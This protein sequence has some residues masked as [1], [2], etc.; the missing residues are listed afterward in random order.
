MF[1]GEAT[2][3][4]HLHCV[5]ENLQHVKPIC[6]LQHPREW[7]S[8]C[9]CVYKLFI[10]QCL[11]HALCCSW[12]AAWQ[13]MQACTVDFG[14]EACAKPVL[15]SSSVQLLLCMCVH[16]L[17]GIVSWEFLLLNYTKPTVCNWAVVLFS[18]SCYIC[19]YLLTEYRHMFIS[20]FGSHSYIYI[21]IYHRYIYIYIVH[22]RMHT[23]WLG[24][25]CTYPDLCKH[26][27]A[28]T[29][30]CAR[31]HPPTHSLLKVAFVL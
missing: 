5:L 12:L 8:W 9:M 31:V 13:C 10:G 19:T 26:I 20:F 1:L 16:K 2:G 23:L 25:M 27:R 28:G 11:H 18:I 14:T 4:L 29:A 21:H 15:T 22:T 7:Q 24:D 6:P 17:N 30:S 3:A